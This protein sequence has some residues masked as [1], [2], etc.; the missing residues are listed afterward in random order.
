MVPENNKYPCYNRSLKNIESEEWE[1]IPGFDG[2]YMV[3]N[4]G[5]IKRMKRE[6]VN[7]RGVV[8]IFKE[9]IIAPRIS[10]APNHYKKDFTYHLF[11]HFSLEGS[12]YHLPIR[13]L[14]YYCFIEP[15]DLKDKTIII[16]CVNGNG[17]DVRPM[18]L[19]L[20]GLSEASLRV[21]QLKRRLP[22]FKNV[23]SKKASRASTR[24][25]S[26]QISQYD[27]TGNK[28][29]TYPSIMEASRQLDIAHSSISNAA[30]EREPTGG[31][32]YWRFGDA[33]YFNVA[34]F[35]EKRSIGFKEK[36][37]TKVT[38]YSLTG[39]RIAQFLT[40]TDAAKSI[41]KDYTGISAAIRG[42][43][44][45]AYGYIWKRGWGKAKINVK[46]KKHAHPEV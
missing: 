22:E 10:L 31:G 37:G 5:R 43:I 7:S 36:K 42:V 2:Y 3:S 45:S 41:G 14:V 38:Q 13:R 11:A 15:F 4:F 30:H 44:T 29:K 40:L 12:R 39:H 16:I 25:T 1:D 17:L 21:M 26:R 18:N 20:T 6:Q 24:V 27:H 9:Q 46:N 34:A 33:S 35:L 32:Y 23:D 8:R 28:I 19:K